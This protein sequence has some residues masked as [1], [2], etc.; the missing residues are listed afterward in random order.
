MF[1]YVFIDGNRCIYCSVVQ[2]ISS[3]A[4]LQL[5]TK[6]QQCKYEVPKMLLNVVFQ[7]IALVLTKDQVGL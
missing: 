1:S 2:P 7:E 4:Q 5:C 6:P 3:G